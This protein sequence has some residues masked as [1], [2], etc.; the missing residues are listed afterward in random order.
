MSE[1]WLVVG[2]G[3]QLGADLLAILRA[4]QADVVGLT[5]AELDVTDTAAV[6][7]AV[8]AASPTIVINAA[9]YTAVDAAETDEEAAYAVNAVAPGQLAAALSADRAA[10]S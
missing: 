9:A 2:A 10:A 5:R 8:A 1:R 6:S 4:Q 7:A 3:G